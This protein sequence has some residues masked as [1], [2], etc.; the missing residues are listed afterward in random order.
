MGIHLERDLEALDGDLLRLGATVESAVLDATCA[1]LER[2]CAGACAVLASPEFDGRDKHRIG[3]K[4]LKILA[5]HQPEAADLHHILAALMAGGDLEHMSDLAKEI[6][7]LALRLLPHPDIR[8]PTGLEQLA[9]RVTTRVRQALE[10]FAQRD[11]VL[12]R[13]TLGTEQK[14]SLLLVETLNELT[15]AMRNIPQSAPQGLALYSMLHHL[16]RVSDHAANI[17]EGVLRTCKRKQALH[18]A[19]VREELD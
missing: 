12:A 9:R 2:D 4:C 16:K 3:E 1:L 18:P 6:A 8:P 19:P 7:R 5:L 11:P 10:A 15:A 13:R 17:A 14:T